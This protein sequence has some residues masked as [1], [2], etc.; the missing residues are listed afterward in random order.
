VERLIASAQGSRDIYVLP[1][2]AQG[3]ACYRVI[4]G[5]YDSRD[6][7]ESAKPSLPGALRSGDVA[8]VA[9][10]RFLR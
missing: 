10:S 7:A 5:L 8:P 1:T 9:V 6:A 4:W 2:T 3:R